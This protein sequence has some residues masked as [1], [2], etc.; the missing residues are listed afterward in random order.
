MSHLSLLVALSVELQPRSTPSN[1]CLGSVLAGKLSK[2]S[3]GFHIMVPLNNNINAFRCDPLDVSGGGCWCCQAPSGESL[4]P[5][6]FQKLR[7]SQLGRLA[8]NLQAPTAEYSHAAKIRRA[9]VLSGWP[10]QAACSVSCAVRATV[11]NL[12]CCLPQQTERTLFG[13]ARGPL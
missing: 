13:E 9:E 5:K 1:M 8:S 12:G 7:F 2:R 11:L 6:R 3:V 10:I 4:W